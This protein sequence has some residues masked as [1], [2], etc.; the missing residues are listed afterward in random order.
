M[1]ALFTN[2]GKNV[3]VRFIKNDNVTVSTYFGNI[4]EPTGTQ[5]GELKG[6]FMDDN[7]EDVA[8]SPDK[9][10]V[11]M[12]TPTATGIAGTTMKADGTGKKQ[13]FKSDFT[14]WLI[15]L[16]NK[17]IGLTTKASY[18]EP[19]Y[20]YTVDS[21]GILKRTLPTKNGLTTNT[22]PDGN[23]VLYS[24]STGTG[25]R[26]HIYNQKT[27]SDNNTG[28]QTLPEKCTW[29]TDSSTAYCGVQISTLVGQ[30][31]DDWYQGTLHMDDAFWKVDIKTNSTSEINDGEGRYLD[32]TNPSIDQ[33]GRYLLIVNKNDGSLW[34]L[35]LN[36]PKKATPKTDTAPALPTTN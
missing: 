9:K 35:D 13:I 26:L 16:T 18:N 31:P 12:L 7:I 21:S 33:T 27:G 36:P 34:S 30:Y 19:G 4:I 2:Q 5:N 28:L 25:V 8:V 14:E 15:D 23:I 20:T 24:E 10:T 32:I 6:T 29:S 22:S 1:I 3:I 11:V 17:T